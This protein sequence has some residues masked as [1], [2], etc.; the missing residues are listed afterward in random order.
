[1]IKN[2]RQNEILEILKQDSFA[3]V[4]SL[5]ERLYAS[6]PTI[7]R[8]LTVL[9]DEGYVKR[10]HGGAMIL[11]ENTKPPVYF[12]REQ[13]MHKKTNMCRVAATLIG[14]SDTVFVDASTSVFHIIDFIDKSSKTTVITNGLPLATAL[15]DTDIRVYSTGGRLLKESLA[16]VGAAAEEAVGTYNADAVFFSVASLSL[17]GTLSD[18]SEDEATLRRAMARSVG[19]KILLCD[20]SK[21][22]TA[23]TFKL[24]DLSYVNFLVTD[25]Q[26]PDALCEKY[27]LTV[28]TD[29]PAYLYKV[30]K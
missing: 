5:A 25:K 28:I 27:N 13:N 26:A 10:C 20:S 19:R 12:R 2:E 14:E 6:M 29:T 18:W 11:D 4:T 9:E 17:D 8:D 22:G 7:R 23:S 30:G 1:M 21:I 3:T 24:F 15:A 16:F